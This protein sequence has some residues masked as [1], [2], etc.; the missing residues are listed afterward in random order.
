MNDS[1]K[2]EMT[3]DIISRFPHPAVLPY[4]KETQLR[5]LKAKILNHNAINFY[6]AVFKY[7]TEEIEPFL[8]ILNKHQHEEKKQEHQQG[9]WAAALLNND[10]T[11]FHLVKEAHLEEDMARKLEWLKGLA[12][13]AQS[14]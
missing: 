14:D 10:A 13:Y 9:A 4:L 12:K 8:D 6:S 5:L 11:I 1:Y 7:P 3:M 2:Y